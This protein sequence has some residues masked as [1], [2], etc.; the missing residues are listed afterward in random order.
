MAVRASNS[1]AGRITAGSLLLTLSLAPLAPLFA[2]PAG[3]AHCAPAS[4][5]V[6]V[7]GPGDGTACTHALGCASGPGAVLPGAIE[8]RLTPGTS[9]PPLA[10]PQT[11]H[12][13]SGFKPPTPPPNR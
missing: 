8:V 7:E 11:R 9:V 3:M 2:R 1:W 12:E 13:R 5:T 6:R 10:P 4:A